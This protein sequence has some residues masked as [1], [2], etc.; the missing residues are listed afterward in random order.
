MGRRL[1][2]VALVV[3]FGATMLMAGRT[4][5]AGA[6][7]RE[8]GRVLEL[9]P[10]DDG[11]YDMR[12]RSTRL[13][14]EPVAETAVLWLPQGPR[15]GN[16]VAW[17][18][19]TKGIADQCAPSFA[20]FGEIPI[21]NREAFLAAGDVVVAPDYEGLG[22]PGVHPYLVGTS[23]GRSILDAIRAA[24]SVTGAE[25]RSAVYG[26]SQGGQGALFAARMAEAYAPDV[27]LVGA[28]AIAPVT[29][30]TSMVDGSSPLSKLPGMVALV[31]AGYVETYPELDA[32]DLLDQPLEQLGVARSDCDAA[33][34]L[35]GT[36]TAQ[37]NAEWRRR[38][39]QNDPA[40]AKTTVPVLI[41]H[42]TDDFILPIPD[43]A[44]TFRRL[45]RQGSTVRFDRY[46]NANHLSVLEASS[47]D[48]F[49]WI[50]D[51]LAGQ[52]TSG[53]QR[54]SISA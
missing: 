18:H 14:G 46:R 50:Q 10:R 52:R 37:P 6:A 51:R 54:R 41:S 47:G 36:T 13:D 16:V 9:T 33:T 2:A 39:R 27:R 40:S 44:L 31:A 11:G 38:L 49:N 15:S 5:Q 32:V 22:A 30:M 4:V 20:G 24:R 26:W 21:P 17:G 42:G 19:S 48:I 29:N 8:A 53:C 12:Y 34:H 3:A 43:V 45:C 7:T 23:E 28:V 35:D 1:I 25:G